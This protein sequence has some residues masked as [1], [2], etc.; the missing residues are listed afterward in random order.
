MPTP[1]TQTALVTGATS[2]IGYELARCFAQDGINLL[3]VARRQAELAAIK[4]DF[5]QQY[6]IQVS[7]L[8]ADLGVPGQAAAV[9]QQC[10]EQGVQLDYLVNNAGFGSYKDVVQEDAALYDNMLTLNVLAVTTLTALVARDMVRRR[11]GRILNVGSTSAFQP[12]PHMAVYGASKSYIM[13]FTEALHAELRGT[14]VTAT[15]LSP[16]VTATSFLARA[17]MGSWS[18]A[19]GKL[20]T[21]AAVAAAGYRAMQQGRLNVVT[22]LK[23]KLLA[24]S[25]SLVPFRGLKLAISAWFMREGA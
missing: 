15:V 24:L 6:G 1:A 7:C 20:P 10:Q 23:N 4:V 9:Y 14:G 12:V 3:L 25:S 13:S 8:V 5:E 17:E 19:Q 11:T 21:A 22:G 16:G 2:G 18:Q